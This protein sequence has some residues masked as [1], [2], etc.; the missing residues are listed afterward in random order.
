MVEGEQEERGRQRDA[1]EDAAVAR[2]DGAGQRGDAD[3]EQPGR[4]RLFGGDEG[5]QAFCAQVSR[6]MLECRK[7][8]ARS[9][10]CSTPIHRDT[11]PW[12]FACASR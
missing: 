3:V 12:T 6:C 5:F 11:T 10:A 1:R 7:N 8:D 4:Q 9:T 2:E